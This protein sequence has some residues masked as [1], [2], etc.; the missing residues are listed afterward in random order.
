[1]S[2]LEAPADVDEWFGLTEAELPIGAAVEW[3]TQS[4]CGA[5]VLFTGTVRDHAEGR[6]GVTHLEYEAYETEVVPKLAEV[7][8]EARRRW[9]ELGRLALLHRVGVVDVGEVSVVVVVSAPHRPEAFDGARFAI[10]TL[11]E[12]VPIWKREFWSDGADWGLGANQV[13]TPDRAAAPAESG[14]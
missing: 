12:T 8:S 2:G 10:D 7:A 14:R 11:K 5:V 9:P 1:V 4:G 3:A 13:T 6:A